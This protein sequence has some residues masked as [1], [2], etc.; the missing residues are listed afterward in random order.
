M[1]RFLIDRNPL[2]KVTIRAR[3]YFDRL[4]DFAECN[5]FGFICVLLSENE[6]RAVE[7][8]QKSGLFFNE[9]CE[10]HCSK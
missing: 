3:N 2:Q 1:F 9:I 5:F 8:I 4:T 7:F 6:L 10:Y